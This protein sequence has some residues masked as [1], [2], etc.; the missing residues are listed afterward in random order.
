[1]WASILTM[2]PVREHGVFH[3]FQPIPSVP[4]ALISR[5]RANGYH[6][7]SVFTD[8]FTCAVG[9]RAGFDEDRSGPAG[10]RQLLLAIVADNS[11]LIPLLRPALPRIWPSLTPPNH[12]GTYTYDLRREVR[13]IFR[14]GA[15]DRRTLV[16]AHINYA[17]HPAYPS[18]RDLSWAELLQIAQAP[19]ARLSDRTFDWQDRDEESDPVKLH[20]WKLKHVQEVITA[21][22]DASQYLGDGRRLVVFSD[23]GDRAGLELETFAD[24]RYYHVPLATFGLA[25][26]CPQEP[27]SLIDIAALL[28]LS[29]G[30]AAPSVEFTMAPKE[31][32]LTLLQTSRVRWPGDVDLDRDLLA[33]VLE[34][35]QRHDPWGVVESRNCPA[36]APANNPSQSKRLAEPSGIGR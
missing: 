1:V 9:S 32:W 5:A 27:I 6:T 23:H 17:H 8:Q 21:E 35:L 33:E 34:G 19:A 4:P 14:A 20:V 26:Q 18:A 2:T 13:G 3:T 28:D 29:D 16:A 7:V 11:L 24:K 22:V 12:A 25:A 36:T 15:K 30:H 31:Q 10:W